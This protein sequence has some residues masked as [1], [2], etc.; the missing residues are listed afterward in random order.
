MNNFFSLE[1]VNLSF[2]CNSN[3][4]RSAFTCFFFVIVDTFLYRVLF[5]NWG[6]S[7]KARG[8]SLKHYTLKK[9]KEIEIE[10]SY[11]TR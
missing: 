8:P 10:V 9:K 4:I 5:T 6:V 11:I 7:H 3:N 1:T 2:V